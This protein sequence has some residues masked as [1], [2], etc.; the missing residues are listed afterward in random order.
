MPQLPTPL[1][2]VTVEIDESVEDAF[3]LWYDREHLPAAL[4]CPGVLRGRRYAT[5]KSTTSN[6]RGTKASTDTKTYLAL[7]ELETDDPG[8]AL[9]RLTAALA[10]MVQTDALDG[11]SIAS[12]LYLPVPTKGTR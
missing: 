10:S 7:Y 6:D 12:W 8:A 3:N 11:T 9:V 1:L 2:L 4:A 5:S